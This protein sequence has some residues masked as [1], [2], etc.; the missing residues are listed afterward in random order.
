MTLKDAARK[1]WFYTRK[2]TKLALLS[3]SI[4]LLKL[5]QCT[6]WLGDKITLD[7]QGEML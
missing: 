2:L 3:L 7:D 5:A 6:E 4:A 1:G